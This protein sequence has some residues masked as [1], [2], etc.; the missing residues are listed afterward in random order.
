MGRMGDLTKKIPDCNHI[1]KK[2][3][4]ERNNVIQ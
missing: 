2:I 4:E 1:E 3:K